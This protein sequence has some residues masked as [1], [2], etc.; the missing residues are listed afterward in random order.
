MLIIDH[1]H[2]FP[3]KDV[4]LP[5][6]IRW[7]V[8]EYPA[9]QRKYSVIDQVG[10]PVS[11]LFALISPVLRL[12]QKLCSRLFW[13]CQGTPKNVVFLIDNLTVV[14]ES[15]NILQ[16]VVELPRFSFGRRANVPA[17]HEAQHA[18]SGVLGAQ[19]GQKARVGARKRRLWYRHY[20][21]KS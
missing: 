9:P 5:N 20:V 21:E 16:G 6:R 3:L 10:Q 8:D 18:L 2:P 12:S 13:H 11:F 15:R 7:D 17:D 14:K 19:S 1:P 4:L